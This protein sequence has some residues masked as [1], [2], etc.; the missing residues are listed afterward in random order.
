MTKKVKATVADHHFKG[1]ISIGNATLRKDEE[2]KVKP[3]ITLRNMVNAGN[4]IITEGDLSVENDEKSF[5]KD[6]ASGEKGEEDDEE[7]G[8]QYEEMTVDEL[9]ELCDKNNLKKS[10]NKSELIERLKNQ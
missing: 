3:N 2:T 5:Q 4:V 6:D 7:T 1:E 10:G 9:K 8:E